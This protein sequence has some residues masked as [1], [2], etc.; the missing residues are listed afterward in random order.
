MKASRDNIGLG[1]FPLEPEAFRAFAKVNATSEEIGQ[2]ATYLD[3]GV[4]APKHH[5]SESILKTEIVL[6]G[7]YGCDT[8]T[9]AI[10]CLV[11]SSRSKTDGFATSH[12]IKLDSI[13]VDKNSR[14]RGLGV[15]LVSECFAE[16]IGQPGN[17]VTHLYAH[18]VHPATVRL[19]RTLTFLDPPPR[20]APISSLH[21]EEG[22]DGLVKRC[23][24]RLAS[25]S[26]S[27]K[28]HCSYCQAN[29]RK[30]RRWCSKVRFD[31]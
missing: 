26:T 7:L 18:S 29:S 23:N 31:A 27:L 1:F 14:R 12:A 20:G 2:I 4:D 22:T 13:I 8:L 21:L 17:N 15:A 3:E 30:A 28:L 6:M 9:A 11:T 16:I 25:V 24:D 10:C 5:D 19:L